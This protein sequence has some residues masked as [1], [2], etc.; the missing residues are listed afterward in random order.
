[1]PST[2]DQITRQTVMIHRSSRTAPFLFEDA[3]ND[4][5]RGCGETDGGQ[6]ET[7]R[8]KERE[9]VCVCVCVC[10]WGGYPCQNSMRSF[11]FRT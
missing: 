6:K 4:R 9:S 10:V 2:S 7:D 3:V 1:M 5:N 11:W 8:Q